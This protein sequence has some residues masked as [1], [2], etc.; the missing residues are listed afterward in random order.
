MI[1][2]KENNF[3]NNTILKGILFKNLYNSHQS[4][5]YLAFESITQPT[6]QIFFTRF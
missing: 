4:F 3:K 6:K 2:K 5:I 1:N